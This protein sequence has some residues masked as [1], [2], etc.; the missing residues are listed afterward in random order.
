LENCFLFIGRNACRKINK[1][2][3]V[4]IRNFDSQWAVRWVSPLGAGGKQKAV[5]RQLFELFAQKKI[6][7]ET[8]GGNGFLS[9]MLVLKD[10]DNGRT[11]MIFTDMD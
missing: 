3:S 2:F 1:I 6:C 7:L 5:L 10:T 11:K 4:F 8:D 9:T